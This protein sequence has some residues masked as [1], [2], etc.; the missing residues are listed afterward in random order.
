MVLQVLLS[1][2]WGVVLLQALEQV[3]QGERTLSTLYPL[4]RFVACVFLCSI[5]LCG[6]FVETVWR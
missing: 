5:F 6:W 3:R 2:A 1:L 4:A